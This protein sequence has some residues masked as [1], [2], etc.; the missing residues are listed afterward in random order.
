MELLCV[1]FACSEM[2]ESNSYLTPITVMNTCTGS[3]CHLINKHYR[4][5]QKDELVYTKMS[6]HMRR[7][8]VAYGRVSRGGLNI[9]AV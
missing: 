3:R 4:K 8:W 2:G 6:L 5:G 7:I 9:V 1:H